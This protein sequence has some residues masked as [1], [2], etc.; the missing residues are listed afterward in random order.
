M[1]LQMGDVSLGTTTP[2]MH[3]AGPVLFAAWG[4][5]LAVLI[6]DLPESASSFAFAFASRPNGADLPH[7]HTQ[8]RGGGI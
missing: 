7:A 6:L 4:D 1:P 3:W 8:R 2:I 5:Q